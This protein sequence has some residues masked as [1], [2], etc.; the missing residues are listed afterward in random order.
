PPRLTAASPLNTKSI[1]QVAHF[2]PPRSRRP[3]PFARSILPP[4]LGRN[5][6]RCTD[7]VAGTRL[8]SGV[9]LR[10]ALQSRCLL[11]CAATAGVARRY[12]WRGVVL[13]P[14]RALERLAR[15]LPRSRGDAG[16]RH[17]QLAP[18]VVDRMPGERI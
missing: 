10:R 17:V 9:Q 15:L 5:L 11:P 16:C 6:D 4:P 13:F 3:E 18:A 1:G 7:G 14:H 8:K 2:L 12:G